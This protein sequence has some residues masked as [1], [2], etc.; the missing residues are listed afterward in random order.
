MSRNDTVIEQNNA[1][2]S[3][4][5]WQG[6]DHHSVADRRGVSLAD[7]IHAMYG[8]MR[9]AGST[10]VLLIGGGGGTLGTM[11]D[12][13]GV[14]VTMVD[15]NPAA[16]EIARRYFNLAPRVECHVADGVEFL[17]D[18]RKRYDAIAL[19]AYSGGAMPRVFTRASFFALAKARMRPGRS[20]FLANVIAADDEDRRPDR[21][22]RQMRTAWR[23]VSLLDCDGYEDR[24]VVVLAGALDGLKPP[25]LTMRPERCV[26]SIANSL[27]EMEFREPR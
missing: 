16:F 20:L 17:K 13:V 18:H 26:R 8:L 27:A 11:L 19:D 9:Q 22:A 5:F 25:R 3:V 24:N 14:R 6:P 10:E 21:L 23:D 4:S 1:T 12:R 15:I 2:G 7:Y